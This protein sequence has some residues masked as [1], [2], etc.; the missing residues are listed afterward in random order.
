V[1]VGEIE[2][3]PMIGNGMRV[4]GRAFRI[5]HPQAITAK[6]RAA[7]RAPQDP[8]RTPEIMLDC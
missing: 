7:K 1:D 5:V 2:A 4:S 3:E 6:A 8:F